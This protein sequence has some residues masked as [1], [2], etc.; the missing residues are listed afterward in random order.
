MGKM[1][2]DGTDIYFYFEVIRQLA[3]MSVLDIGMFLKR[4]GAVARQAVSCELSR[5]ILLFGIDFFPE[6]RLAV[7]EKIY[8]GILL[9][10]QLLENSELLQG[11]EEKF[12]LAVLIGVAEFLDDEEENQLVK[13]LKFITCGCV[14]DWAAGDRLMQRIPEAEYTPLW[15]DDRPYVWLQFSD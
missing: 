10:N 2:T 4:I 1:I 14:A 15:V 8:N 13:I 9:K 12:D 11:M 5:D 3:P 6:V 7:Y